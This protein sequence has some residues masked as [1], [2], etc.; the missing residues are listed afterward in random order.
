MNRLI[1]NKVKKIIPKISAT[2]LIAL[3]SGTVSLDGEIFKGKVSLPR[4]LELPQRN[5]K[6]DEG[7]HNLLTKFGSQQQIYPSENIGKI[8]SEIGNNKLLSLIIKEKWGGNHCSTTHLSELL[9]K[10][11]SVNPAL[12]VTVMVPNSLG[13]AELLYSYGTKEQQDRFLPK[14]ANGELVPCFGL[15]GPNN[16]SDAVGSIDRGEVVKRGDKLFIQIKINKRYITLA[17]VANIAGIAFNLED[18]NEFLGTGKSGITVALVEKDTCGLQ[19]ETHHNPLNVGFPNGTLKGDLL[20]PID[21]VIGGVENVGEGWKMLMECLAAGR[22][23]C[24]PATANACAK[25]STVGIWHYINNR[26]QFKIPLMKMEAVSNKFCDMVYHT[27]I[28]QSG[29]A[30]TNNLL[31]SGEKPAVISAIMKQQT[32]DRAREVLN[33]GMDI[34]A[35]SAICLGENNFMEKFYRSAPIGI[36]VEGSNT[37]TRNLIIFG[38]GLN[39]SHPHI[40]DIFNSIQSNDLNEFSTKFWSIVRGGTSL[41]FSSLFK[42]GSIAKISTLEHF[43]FYRKIIDTQTTKFATLSNFVALLGGRIKSNQTISALMADILSNIYLANSVIY[44]TNEEGGNKNVGAYCLYRLVIDTNEKINLVINNYPTTSNALKLVLK[45]LSASNTNFDYDKNREL[46]NVIRNNEEDV[47]GS[48]KENII[49]DDALSRLETLTN[50]K[51]EIEDKQLDY[52]SPIHKQ[53]RELYDDVVSV[54]EYPIKS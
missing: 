33:H 48:L 29:I 44:Y 50:L 22:G 23:V 35:G 2:E 20:I 4:K 7:V 16:G 51:R 28:I 21:Q 54:G 39:K 36:T 43:D 10:L 24:L 14:L 6:L 26:Q 46:M 47:L 41:Y 13:P 37:L 12:G 18:P 27:W 40:Y 5:I 31:D 11:S 52:S 42:S 17:P 32:T 53:Y 45:T 9:T 15:T 30:L 25:V 3:R 38:Q 49:L 19:Q 34:H 8:M 1:F